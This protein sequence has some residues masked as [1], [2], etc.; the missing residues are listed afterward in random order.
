MLR[1]VRVAAVFAVLALAA[2]SLHSQDLV[3]LC[4][5]V[6]NPP[7]GAWSAFRFVGG[8]EDGA[9]MKISVV[10]TEAHGDT[11]YKWLE[12][13]MNG[14]K[15]GRGESFSGVSKILVPSFGPGMGHPRAMVLKFGNAPAMTMPTGGPMAA[16]SGGDRTGIEK[17][18]EGK[19]L[20]WENVTVPGG[21]FRALHVQDKDGNGDVWVMPSMPLGLIK[22]HSDKESGGDMVLTGHGMGAKTAITEAPVP[23]NPTVL[24]QMM[25]GQNSH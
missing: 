4:K 3:A 8:Q 17:C 24:M 15:G 14:F 18:G 22:M 11:T 16:M 9:T 23:F 7:V 19:S 2:T 5:Q 25:G 21:T 10:G 6:S 12:I 13:A 1:P 20:G